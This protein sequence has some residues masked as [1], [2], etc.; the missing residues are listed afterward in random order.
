M[1]KEK[2]TK[3]V[4]EYFEK[5]RNGEVEILVS[6]EERLDLGGLVYDGGEVRIDFESFDDWHRRFFKRFFDGVESSSVFIPNNLVKSHIR[7]VKQT[8]FDH[9]YYIVNHVKNTNTGRT[10]NVAKPTFNYPELCAALALLAFEE[11]KDDV[12]HG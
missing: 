4:E 6:K 12:S 5:V 7:K 10:N 3:S 8:L 11:R 1:T 2:E 9:T